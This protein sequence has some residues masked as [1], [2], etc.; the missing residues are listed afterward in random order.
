[1]P[2]AY[3]PNL[4]KSHAQYVPQPRYNRHLSLLRH[5]SCLQVHS[6]L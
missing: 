6:R 2:I 5:C 1:M 4:I 3:Y